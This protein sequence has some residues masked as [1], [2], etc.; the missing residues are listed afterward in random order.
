M[1]SQGKY[2]RIA[3]FYD[4]LKGGDT[5]RW[6]KAQTVF[7]KQMR[8]KVL[9]AGIGTGQEIVHFP[10]GLD[11]SAIDISPNMIQGAQKR[12]TEYSGKIRPVL[13]NVEDLGFPADCFDTIL[14]VCMLCT[15]ERP[16]RGLRELRRVLKPNG[17]IMMFEHVLSK[18]PIYGA[19]LKMMN[20]VTT[21]VSGTHLD[22]DTVGNLRQ[23]GF[24]VDSKRNIYL[25]IVKAVVGHKK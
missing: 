21:R 3:G 19:I 2:D 22:R 6:G 17:K 25:D 11:I 14:T 23:A 24:Q 10:P 4:Y 15:A 7:F 1:S 20:V 12:I 8:G 16:V 5:R 13:M 9:Y 18:N